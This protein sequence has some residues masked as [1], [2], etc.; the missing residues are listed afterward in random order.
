MVSIPQLPKDGVV[1]VAVYW[2]GWALILIPSGFAFYSIYLASLLAN[3]Y[4]RTVVGAGP[5]VCTCIAL[6]VA[7]CYAVVH[8]L[9]LFSII[10][11]AKQMLRVISSAV[12][13]IG[14]IIF[15]VLLTFFTPTECQR[16]TVDFEEYTLRNNQTDARAASYWN[17]NLT[18]AGQHTIL[19]TIT[20][21]SI[22]PKIPLVSFF[23]AW[24]SVFTFYSLG[25]NLTSPITG[26]KNKEGHTRLTSQH[27][28]HDQL[29]IREEGA[30]DNQS[31]ETEVHP[32][33]EYSYYSD[34][35]VH[36][37]QT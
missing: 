34:Y 1:E 2:F 33:E 19:T 10:P 14:L 11:S 22:S 29:S 4:W 21:R 15:A 30:Q 26:M 6:V 37:D 31:R 7:L 28:D 17:M 13:L 20:D 12:S 25:S 3:G 8:I 36:Q 35:T 5:L 9:H 32:E 16:N 27:S 24:I 23:M 18:A